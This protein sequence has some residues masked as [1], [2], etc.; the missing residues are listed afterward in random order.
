MFSVVMK[1][2]ITSRW[3]LRYIM[4]HKK[5]HII[6][7]YV[8][9][10]RIYTNQQYLYLFI[11]QFINI[12]LIISPDIYFNLLETICWINLKY[13]EQTTFYIIHW[14][15]KMEIFLCNYSNVLN[16]Y[17]LAKVLQYKI[18]FHFNILF[19]F[20]KSYVKWIFYWKT[21]KCVTLFQYRS[22]WY[23]VRHWIESCDTDVTAIKEYFKS[24]VTP[25]K[26]Q[27]T[28]MTKFSLTYLKD[29][30]SDSRI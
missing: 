26:D 11:T 18:S 27:V 5:H 23:K 7:L 10:L 16:L 25:S 20:N 28:L 1:P 6:C 8:F 22:K 24:V 14:M 29:F 17:I 13:I 2:Y 15:I 4:F 19:I 3:T 30:R 12:T 21:I 9:I